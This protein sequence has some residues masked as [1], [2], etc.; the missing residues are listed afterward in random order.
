[1]GS[2]TADSFG[3]VFADGFGSLRM[4]SGGLGRFTILVVTTIKKGVDRS[5]TKL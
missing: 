4:V 3:W 1:M 2:V 5:K